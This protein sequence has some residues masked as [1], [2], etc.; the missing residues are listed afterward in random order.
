[1]LVPTRPPGR[2][3]LGLCGSRVGIRGLGGVGWDW[4]M[5]PVGPRKVHAATNTLR[6]LTY[7]LMNEPSPTKSLGAAFATPKP[8]ILVRKPR[9]VEKTQLI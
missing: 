5:F 4:L 1:M 6:S 3:V 9:P 8:E 2:R 7:S